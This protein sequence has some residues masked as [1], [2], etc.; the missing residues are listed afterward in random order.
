MVGDSL[1]KAERKH[2]T[3]GGEC[4]EIYKGPSKM[5]LLYT[6]QSTNIH[7][8]NSRQY[9]IRILFLVIS[10]SVQEK[11]FC[12]SLLVAVTT[13]SL[14]MAHFLATVLIKATKFTLLFYFLTQM[15]SVN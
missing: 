15:C 11:L 6:D 14:Y 8:C 1:L 12:S 3:K 5:Y 4:R 13:G 2:C 10:K 7:V 9:V